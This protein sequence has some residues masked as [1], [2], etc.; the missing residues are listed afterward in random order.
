MILKKNGTMTVTWV[1]QNSSKS[2]FRQ[3]KIPRRLVWILYFPLGSR[4]FSIF[5]PLAGFSFECFLHSI[6]T[7]NISGHCYISS[8]NVKGHPEWWLTSDNVVKGRS[9][10]TVGHSEEVLVR[11]DQSARTLVRGNVVRDSQDFDRLKT[12][13]TSP[14]WPTAFCGLHSNSLSDVNLLSGRPLWHGVP[15]HENRVTFSYV[16]VLTLAE[17]PAT[18]EK[19]TR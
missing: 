6:R 14:E 15:K 16:A 10:N 11:F 12:S 19:E 18:A 4:P 5:D 1:S 3:V 13:K 8:T 2:K 7:L 17:V 9:Q